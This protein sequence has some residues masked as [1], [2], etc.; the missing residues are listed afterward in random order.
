MKVHVKANRFAKPALSWSNRD[1]L[2]YFSSQLKQLKGQGLDIP[3]AAWQGFLSRIVG[4][5]SKLKLNN[6]QYKDFIDNVFEYFTSN[7]DYVPVFGVI[8]SEKV[9]YTLAKLKLVA[10]NNPSVNNAEF[11][12]LRD[13]LYSNIMLF[14]KL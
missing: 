10:K 4:F 9:Y 5:R 14:K 6:V 1:F 2:M 8:V 11:L 7:P 12:V 3:P 13:Q